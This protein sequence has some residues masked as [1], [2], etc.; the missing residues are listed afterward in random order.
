MPGKEYN[1]GRNAKNKK[2][3]QYFQSLRA[4]SSTNYKKHQYNMFFCLH[5]NNIILTTGHPK[6]DSQNKFFLRKIQPNQDVK[7]ALPIVKNGIKY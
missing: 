2:L 6:R 1:K 5:K 3:M 7:V 4:K